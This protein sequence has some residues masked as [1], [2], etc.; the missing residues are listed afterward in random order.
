MF[1]LVPA[2][3]GSPRQRAVKRL[4]LLLLLLL[5]S[6]RGSELLLLMVCVCVKPMED[7]LPP[8]DE[9]FGSVSGEDLDLALEM[10]VNDA[11][12]DVM[13]STNLQPSVP[14]IVCEVINDIVRSASASDADIAA[15]TDAVN[16]SAAHPDVLPIELTSH[17]AQVR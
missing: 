1:L 15:L 5:F 12:E 9:V 8:L 13:N 11:V 7:A 14:G 17:D 2:H 3:L 10:V 16:G 4:L 6:A